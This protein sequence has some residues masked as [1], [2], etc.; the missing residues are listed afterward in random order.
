V[1]FC[2]CTKFDLKEKKCYD[3]KNRDTTMIE[4]KD[5]ALLGFYGILGR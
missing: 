5:L 3:K 4:E 2:S 1:A